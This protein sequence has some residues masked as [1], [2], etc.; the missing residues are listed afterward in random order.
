LFSYY[1]KLAIA[2]ANANMYA[3][4]SSGAFRRCSDTCEPGMDAGFIEALKKHSV[5]I[6]TA[7]DAH[8]P[9]DVGFYIKEMEKMLI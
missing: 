6:Q 2:L 8:C 3:E 1:D 5:K 9:E 4:Q 7:S